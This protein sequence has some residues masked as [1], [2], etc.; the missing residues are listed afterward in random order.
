[1]KEIQDFRE[2][3]SQLIFECLLL[4][5]KGLVGTCLFFLRI[6]D[7]AI[8]TSN[9]SQ[10][11]LISRT[12]IRRIQTPFRGRMPADIVLFIHYRR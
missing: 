12:G 5:L 2:V 10:V 3:E 7:K 1:M 6:T 8:T 9:V 4:F 11:S